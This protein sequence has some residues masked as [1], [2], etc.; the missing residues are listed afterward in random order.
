MILSLVMALA[1]YIVC[2][3]IIGF[4][5][6]T[7]LFLSFT[8]WAWRRHSLPVSLAYALAVT[9]V[10]QFTFGVALGM[11]LPRGALGF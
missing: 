11:P 1:G 7:F 9:L 10:I 5:L 3:P 8:I 2:M 4:C 6:A